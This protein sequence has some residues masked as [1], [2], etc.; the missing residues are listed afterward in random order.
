MKHGEGRKWRFIKQ[1][2]YV[3]TLMVAL[4]LLLFFM[5]LSWGGVLYAW[6]S[7]HV[8]TTIVVGAM[9]LIA[10]GLYEAFMPLK[11]P[12]LPLRAVSDLRLISAIVVWSLGS[13]IYYAFAIIWPT[14]LTVLYA[15]KHSDL[16]WP[17]YAALALNAGISF[18]EILGACLAKKWIHWMIR[19]CFFAGC[20]L[21]AAV[22]SATPDTPGRA[23]ALMFIGTTLIG[24]VELLASTMSSILVKD[25][26]EIGTVIGF[27]GS[28]RSTISTICATYVL[29][30]QNL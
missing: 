24:M 26:R 14:M 28:V 23:I 2:D 4:G 29:S 13:G 6:D 30:I 15:D 19:F 18:G 8:I 11:E 3:G 20:A 10:F 22:A 21:L 16:M 1:F 7:A 5:G 12:L 27:A 9:L 17:G 25:Q